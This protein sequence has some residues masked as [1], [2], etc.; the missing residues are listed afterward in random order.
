MAQNPLPTNGGQLIALGIKM[1]AGIISIGPGVPVTMVNAP[2]LQTVLDAFI[3]ADGAF[4]AARSARQAASDTYQAT[5]GAIYDWLLAVRKVLA[6]RFGARWSTEWA[7]AGFTDATTAVPTK[8]EDRISLVLSLAN[9]FIANP[10]YEVASLDVTAAQGTLLRNAALS[11]QQ[12]LTT[13]LANL[14]TIGDTWATA[15]D[16]LTTV[17]RRLMRNLD[18]MLKPNDPRWVQFGLNIPASP[19]TPGQPAN[20][21]AHTDDTGAIVVQCDAVALAT[22]YR[23]RMLR[24]G[25]EVDYQLATSSPVPIGTIADVPPGQLVQIIVQAVNGSQQSV[26]SEP[27]KFRMPPAQSPA[28]QRSVVLNASATDETYPDA[29]GNGNG[30]GHGNGIGKPQRTAPRIS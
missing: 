30:H 27:L 12:V 23:W 1:H 8:V 21:S 10:S 22:R 15:Y 13:A 6:V 26:A 25:V 2:Q 4:N 16:K 14:T 17:M 28:P 11:A 24:V 29:A 18:G 3:A 5:C 20:L 9:F 7:Q 19:S